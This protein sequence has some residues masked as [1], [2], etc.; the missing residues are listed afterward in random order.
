MIYYFSGTGNSKWVAEQIALKT[1][2]T[3]VNMVEQSLVSSVD[4]QTIGL[5][6]PIYA[7]GAPELV[8]EFVK[9][10]VGQPLF[11]F[12]VCTCGSEAGNAME[13]VSAIFPLNSMYSLAMPSNY[14]MGAAVESREI[15][16]AKIAKA[17]EK[18]K[19]IAA[20]IV[21]QQAVV[22]VNKG[23]SPWVKSTLAN[24]GFNRFSRSTKPF[25]V[26]EKCTS[27]GLCAK[28]CPANTI[29][30]IDGKP[31][32]GEKCYQCT[33]CINRCP[34]SAIEYG[35]ETSTRGRYEFSEQ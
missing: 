22:D 35:K 17:K 25:Y 2:D 33:A 21:A 20:Q 4:Q 1:N 13:K 29:S 14:V 19:T 10:L 32:W 28:N 12:G 11:T 3:A 27:C 6:F 30:M 34:V 23:K 15:I 5:V 26:T 8:L 18:L 24:L 31:H 9:K 16:V 7:W